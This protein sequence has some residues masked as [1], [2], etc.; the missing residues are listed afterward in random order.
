MDDPSSLA[1]TIL[2]IRIVCLYG[3]PEFLSKMLPISKF[4]SNFHLE[5]I[6]VTI[7]AIIAAGD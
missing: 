1:K 5:Q 2:G 3:G 6:D 7:E 4:N